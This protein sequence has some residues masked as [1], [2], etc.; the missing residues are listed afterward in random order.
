[1]GMQPVMVVV[2]LS[3]WC[4]LYD[5]FDLGVFLCYIERLQYEDSQAAGMYRLE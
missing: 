2:S 1:M 5:I 3:L 4:V